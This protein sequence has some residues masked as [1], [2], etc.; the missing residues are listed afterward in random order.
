[1]GMWETF[2]AFLL[3]CLSS[4]SG[5]DWFKPKLMVLHLLRHHA[6]IIHI[7]INTNQNQTLQYS[8]HVLLP[9]MTQLNTKLLKDIAQHIWGARGWC[10]SDDSKRFS[11]R[12]SYTN[13][14]TESVIR[15]GCSLVESVYTYEISSLFTGEPHPSPS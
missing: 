4:L 5:I 2:L 15:G 1:M 9:V 14:P 10:G 8:K 12:D 11:L 6:T 13:C 3:D 7:Y